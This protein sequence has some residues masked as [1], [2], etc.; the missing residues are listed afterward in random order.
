MI[1][2]RTEKNSPC[3]GCTAWCCSPRI[4]GY[5]VPICPREIRKIEHALGRS[6][7]YEK[8]NTHYFLKA[9]K[10]GYCIFFDNDKK[11]CKIYNIR[12]ADCRIFPFGFFAPTETE[13]LWVM[14]DCPFSQQLDPP[15]IEKT[16]TDLE[17]IFAYEIIETWDY[18]NDD[19]AKELLETW[20]DTTNTKTPDGLRILRRV[21]VD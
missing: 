2:N 3:R 9:K 19:Y 8:I 20:G 18:G 16:L 6:D 21:R 5:A 13:G 7:F 1:K 15:G 11:T 14:W 12:P 10:D 17:S 4:I